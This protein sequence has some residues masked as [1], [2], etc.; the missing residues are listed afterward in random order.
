[1]ND[2]N[3]EESYGEVSNDARRVTSDI[4]F[5]DRMKG[6]TQ[7]A[8]DMRQSL[9]EGGYSQ[10]MAEALS[11]HTFHHMAEH[12]VR[13]T[14]TDEAEERKE[15]AAKAHAKNDKQERPINP[16]AASDQTSMDVLREFLKDSGAEIIGP[17]E[18]NN[19][20]QCNCADCRRERGED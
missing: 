8:V 18:I 19:K 20:G 9:I 2:K 7:A 3:I 15:R 10:E 17:F 11:G 16:F 12:V 14:Y 13:T 1:M 6:M 4:G 5:V